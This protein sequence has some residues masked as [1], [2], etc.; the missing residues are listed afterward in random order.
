M[1]LSVI[2][3]YQTKL[4]QATETN[5]VK[6][7]EP[8]LSPDVNTSFTFMSAGRSWFHDPKAGW[9]IWYRHQDMMM[10]GDKTAE[11]ESE[12]RNEWRKT[13]IETEEEGGAQISTSMLRC[14]GWGLEEFTLLSSR[15]QALSWCVH[16][17]S[18]WTGLSF[19]ID[20]SVTRTQHF[21]IFPWQVLL[22]WLGFLFRTLPL[23]PSYRKEGF[24]VGPA[25]TDVRFDVGP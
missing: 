25:H 23:H 22:V 11:D 15:L 12:R 8:L 14:K 16:T 20:S 4:L 19:T 13:E 24:R 3:N 2:A 5:E 6:C 21:C 1:Q 9:I 18:G 10:V 7:W 17:R